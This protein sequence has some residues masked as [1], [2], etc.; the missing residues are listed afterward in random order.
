MFIVVRSCKWYRT[1]EN[2]YPTHKYYEK[3]WHR[4]KSSCGT[5]F[6]SCYRTPLKRQHN[7]DNFIVDFYIPK[8]KIAIELDGIQHLIPKHIEADLKRDEVLATWGIKVLRYSN[9]SV[10]ENYGAVVK[11]I[12]THLDLSFSD[13]KSN[14]K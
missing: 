13:L 3:I 14:K 9:K 5:I 2:L 6:L 8:K 7:I 10:N 4:K 11:D 1:I 12:L